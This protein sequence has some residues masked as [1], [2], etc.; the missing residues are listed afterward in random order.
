M[1]L[2]DPNGCNFEYTVEGLPESTFAVTIPSRDPLRAAEFYTE[3]LGMEILGESDDGVYLRR[4][5][6][7]IILRRSEIVGVDTGILFEVDNPYN[8]RRRLMDEG[9]R[10]LT[11][12]TRGP[13]GTFTTFYD[14]DGNIIGVIEGGAEF[15]S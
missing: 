12:P 11:D 15:R 14:P 3:V 4:K 5:G 8:T 9:V 13:L 7:R 6:C 10:F 2:G 1:P